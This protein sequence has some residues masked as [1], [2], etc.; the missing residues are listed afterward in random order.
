MMLSVRVEVHGDRRVV[1]TVVDPLPTWSLPPAVA[2]EVGWNPWVS[3][4]QQTWHELAFAAAVAGYEV[5]LRGWYS[6]ALLDRLEAATGVRPLTPGDERRPA[7]SDIVIVSAGWHDPLRLA[8][9]VLSPARVVVSMLAP[10]GLF[11]WPLVGPPVQRDP[12]TVDLDE[13]ARPEHFRALAAIGVDV[14][15]HMHRVQELATENGVR[16]HFIGN[17]SPLDPAAPGEL[18]DIDVAYLEGSKWLELAE[19]AVAGLDR[20]AHRILIG[21]HDEV[22]RQIARAKVLVWPARVEGHGRVLWEARV[23]GT[24]VVAL[25]SNVFATGLDE[26][27]G[28]VA[29]DTVEEIPAVVERLLADDD[30]RTR[31]SRAG[32]ASALE[33]VNWRRFVARVDKA[34]E[35][36]DGRADEP[37]A[38]AF[39]WFGRRIDELLRGEV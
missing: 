33:Q 21:S 12:L 29:V 14:F 20:L 19:L 34:I 30:W 22:L 18:K 35:R 4:G 17:G 8:R 3:G 36:V 31:L 25:R 28:T 6:R 15:T 39:A 10:P 27:S 24:V 7:A 23:L 1:I 26:A 37:Q 11:G 32:R 5:E 38:D 2:S 13:L 16:C 9:Y